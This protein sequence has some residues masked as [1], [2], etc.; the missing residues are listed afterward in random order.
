MVQHLFEVEDGFVDGVHLRVFGD[1]SEAFSTAGV[2]ECLGVADFDMMFVL[3][4]C[5]EEVALGLDV[6]D[7]GE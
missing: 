6:G 2:L 7:A 4:E 1:E 5:V 3:E